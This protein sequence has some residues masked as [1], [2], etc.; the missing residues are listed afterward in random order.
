M[1]MRYTPITL[2]STLLAVACNEVVLREPSPEVDAGSTSVATSA[3]D[4]PTNG[5]DGPTTMGADDTSSGEASTSLSDP[6]DSCD[7]LRAAVVE[8][9]QTSCYGC[10]AGGKASGN[11]AVADDL[12]AMLTQG[13]IVRGAPDESPLYQMV[14]A[15]VMPPGGPPLAD[16]EVAAI[17]GFIAGCTD[18][19]GLPGPRVP[20]A[21]PDNADLDSDTVIAAIKTDIAGLQLVDVPSVRYV[22]MTYLHNLG[23]CDDQ[24]EGRRVALS[25]ALNS[26]SRGTKIVPPHRFG[27]ADAIFRI[28]LRD[29]KWTP[30]L[31]A[32][33][34]AADPYAIAYQSSDA[35]FV[36]DLT[37][38]P[39]FMM[40]GEAF[41]TAITRPPLYHAI[42]DIPATR[43]VLEQ[44]FS[45]AVG[46]N[47][48]AEQIADLG[49]VVRA[50]VFDSGVSEHNRAFECHRFPE[51][52]NRGYCLSYDFKSNED[53]A[54]IFRHPLDF[55]ADGGE[56]IFTLANGLQGYMIVDKAGSRIDVAPTEVVVD[57]EHGGEPVVN[58]ISCMGCH[59]SGMRLRADEVAS[60]VAS[61]PEFPDL[62]QES[63]RN[64]YSDPAPDARDN[65]EVRLAALQQRFLESLAATGAPERL[66]GEEP[67]SAICGSFDEDVTFAR[68]AAE[69]GVSAEDLLKQLGTLEGL[70]LL[71]QKPV[72]RA[73][74][75]A[76][77]AANACR[78]NRGVT[79]ACPSA[80]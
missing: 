1:T 51:A 25:K 2:L 10:H 37:G 55:E 29:Y 30:E 36:R 32:Q 63:V 41:I 16:D 68:A 71:D 64:L 31:W 48:A 52:D 3:G 47:L 40:A 78:L 8:T 62:A 45:I 26:L 14:A 27:P 79:T 43:Q 39:V 61:N 75:T 66:D 12:D 19:P 77:F 58:G 65:M 57:V 38:A 76:H 73:T 70:E 42:L 46:E 17:D 74:F 22:D 20:P 4:E 9:L 24:I 50:G 23:Y 18:S 53:K 15:G 21:C 54:D 35:L 28:D 13:Y 69:F 67:I 56:V 6:P 60:V 49:E 5:G 80:P 59:T 72:A 11:F 34:V 7:E 33:I 44:R